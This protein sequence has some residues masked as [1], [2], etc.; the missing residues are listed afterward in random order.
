VQ[1]HRV[2]NLFRKRSVSIH[3]ENG[4]QRIWRDYCVNIHVARI[5]TLY[6]CTNTITTQHAF[7]YVFHKC[8]EF[9]L[10]CSD[11]ERFQIF[12]LHKRYNRQGRG[13]QTLSSMCSVVCLAPMCERPAEISTSLTHD[14]NRAVLKIGCN[15]DFSPT[16]NI[17]GIYIMH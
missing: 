14:S 6:A 5:R 12:F 11:P 4:R 10:T 15:W 1:N 7:P 2:Q 3:R 17:C 13:Q 8:I 9:R 16:D